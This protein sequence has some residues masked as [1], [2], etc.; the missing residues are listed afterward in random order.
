LNFHKHSSIAGARRFTA[1]PDRSAASA[2]TPRVP[3][4]NWFS[5]K[6]VASVFDIECQNE[7]LLH[8]SG[9]PFLICQLLH[10][11]GEQALLSPKTVV[12]V[13][14][15]DCRSLGALRSHL[16]Q[17]FACSREPNGFGNATGELA[18]KQDGEA[19]LNHP[20]YSILAHSKIALIYPDY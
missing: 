15:L 17:T 6:H 20:L 16:Q 3:R 1:F 13:C 11:S 2:S 19:S 12:E 18:A 4:Y 9:V 5:C 7:I 8:F 10:G 14:G